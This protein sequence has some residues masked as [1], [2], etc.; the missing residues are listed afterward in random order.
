MQIIDIIQHGNYN[1]ISI[2]VDREPEFKFER[3]IY[4]ES[5][6][7]WLVAEDS[8]F[9]KFYYFERPTER[10]KAFGGRE[11]DIPMKS[12]DVLHA[13]GQ[14]WD[15][16]P[17]Q[18]TDTVVSV[19]YATLESLKRCYIFRHVYI[20]KELIES[21]MANINVKSDYNCYR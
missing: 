16:V 20:S 14:Y 18:F 9:Y 1:Q 11:F 17:P 3:F 4:P 2:I 10:W 12:G 8:G 6:K 21:C 19:G 7:P 15:G 13:C 5:M